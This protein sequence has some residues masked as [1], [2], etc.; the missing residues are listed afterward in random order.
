MVWGKGLLEEKQ[1]KAVSNYYICGFY[2]DTVG[3]VGNGYFEVSLL[4]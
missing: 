1:F 3:N 2:I 4:I